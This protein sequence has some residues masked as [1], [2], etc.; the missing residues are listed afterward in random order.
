MVLVGEQ[1]VG[2][3]YGSAITEVVMKSDVMDSDRQ[4]VVASSP[5]RKF[6]V[7]EVTESGIWGIFEM[8]SKE[9]HHLISREWIRK[10]NI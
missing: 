9:I 3:D 10:R 5:F 1:F 6:R 7:G 8:L 4:V 2:L